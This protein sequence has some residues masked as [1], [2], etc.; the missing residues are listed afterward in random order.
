MSESYDGVGVRG[1]GFIGECVDSGPWTVEEVMV[2]Y[3][4]VCIYISIVFG[5]Y[6]AT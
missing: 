3:V 6:L 2:V 4:A 5:V 1:V